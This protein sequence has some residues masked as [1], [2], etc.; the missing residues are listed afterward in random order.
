[1]KRI[2][3]AALLATAFIPSAAIAEMNIN[4][5]TGAQAR[6]GGQVVAG[7]NLNRENTIE[8]QQALASKGFFQGS[9]NGVWNTGTADA[10]R[11]FQQKNRLETSGRLDTNTLNEL[12][13][14][15]SMMEESRVESRGSSVNSENRMRTRIG[16]DSESSLNDDMSGRARGS[17]SGSAN[18]QNNARGGLGVG[19]GADIGV[20]GGVSTSGR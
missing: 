18:T 17:A 19:L 3:Y 9:I 13:V 15:L 2:F 10:L 20:G 16:V 14:Q 6:A 8:I 7:E 1:M 4:N 5:R 12:G 11:R